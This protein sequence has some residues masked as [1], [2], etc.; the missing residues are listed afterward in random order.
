MSAEVECLYE[1]GAE[2]LAA[3]RYDAAVEALRDAHSM[4]PR[5]ARIQSLLGLATA[6][7]GGRFD[8]AR[9]LCEEA[10]KREFDNPDLY[11]NLAQVYLGYG[12]RSEALRYL[13]R[14]QMI[15]PENA[16]IRR[17]LAE[18][19]RRRAP[20]CRF[21]PRRHPINRA[22]G[23]LRSQVVDRLLTGH[24]VAD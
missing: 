4:D 18:L 5:N 13:R 19:G 7:A 9:A 8:E 6:R 17:A 22:L 15:D 20:V 16:L 23:S 3:G 2:N 21:L 10:S 11:L 1:R 12:R 14:G 24:Q